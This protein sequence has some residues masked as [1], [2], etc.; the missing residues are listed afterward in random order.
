M[1][2]V[3]PGNVWIRGMKGFYGVARVPS[4]NVEL[5]MEKNLLQ[6]ADVKGPD[7]QLVK[8]G[9]PVQNGPLLGRGCSTTVPCFLT[10]VLHREDVDR[11]RKQF[12]G[13]QRL[14]GCFSSEHPHE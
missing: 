3:H 12:T 11:I 8:V 14:E 10:R 9:A 7:A 5:V 1:I 4:P 2:P 6:T 13:S